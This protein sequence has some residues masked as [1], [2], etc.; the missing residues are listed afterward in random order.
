S[1][2]CTNTSGNCTVTMNAAKSVTATFNSS[3]TCNRS[4]AFV[5][6]GCEREY[7]LPHTLGCNFINAV[8]ASC[9]LG[10]AGQKTKKSTN[11]D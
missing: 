2:A 4:L 9:K 3:S 1:G 8:A 7:G 5:T 11:P 10:Q 6:V